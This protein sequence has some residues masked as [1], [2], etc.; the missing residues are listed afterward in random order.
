M[1]A[2]CAV[3]APTGARQFAFSCD[4]TAEGQGFIARAEGSNGAVFSIDERGMR[5]TE[6]FPGA[7]KLPADCWMVEKDRCQ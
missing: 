5:R 3:P 4:L 2:G 6:Q 1:G 7:V